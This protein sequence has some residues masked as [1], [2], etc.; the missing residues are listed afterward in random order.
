VAPVAGY[1]LD[2]THLFSSFYRDCP[3]LKADTPAALRS[4]L[5]VCRA[6]LQT[7]TNA[8]HLLG[9]TAPERM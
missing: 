4:R 7:L 3:V 5:A 8:L 9:I 2:L 6:T 1:A